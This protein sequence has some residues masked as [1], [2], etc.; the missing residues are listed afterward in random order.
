MK[1]CDRLLREYVVK[2]RR[3]RGNRV[4]TVPYINNEE[5]D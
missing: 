2:R 5:G 1:L 4:I 3:L